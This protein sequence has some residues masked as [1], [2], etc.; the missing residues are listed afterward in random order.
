ME[1]DANKD[2]KIQ[3]S[4]V[5]ERM[6]RFFDRLDQ[7]NDGVLDEAELKS[8]ASRMGG[9]RRRGGGRSRA[10]ARTRTPRP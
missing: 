1:N 4:E 7:N 5:P 10:T 8:M 3:K 9:S 6:G 2:G